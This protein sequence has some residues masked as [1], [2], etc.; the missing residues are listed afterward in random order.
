MR[1]R[2]TGHAVGTVQATVADAALTAQGVNVQA[3]VLSSGNFLVA[4]FTDAD[5]L[6]KATDYNVTINWGD[7]TTSTGTVTGTGTNG[8]GPFNVNGTHTYM[9][10]GVYSAEVTITSSLGATALTTT[11]A[12]FWPRP[13]R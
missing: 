12:R 2:A 1:E 10:L 8:A 13:D 11:P 3:A 7:N 9:T 6:G 4:T 5:P